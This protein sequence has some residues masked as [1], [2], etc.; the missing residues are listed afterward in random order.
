MKLPVIPAHI[1]KIAPLLL[2]SICASIAAV[3]YLQAL[4]YPF[5]IDDSL[6]ITENTRL[7]ELHLS[8]LWR[9]FVEPY[10]PTFEFLP[11]RDLSYWIDIAW[12]GQNPAAFRLHNLLLYLL[13]LPL[14]YATSA[15][16]WRTFRPADAASAPWAAA[17]VTAL[18]ALHPAL[19]ESV[20][21]ISG[22]KYIL[23]N[24]FALLAL[25]LAVNVKQDKTLSSRYA[26]AALLA[27]VAMMFSKSSYVAV[28]PVIALL[29]VIFWCDIPL[30][31]RR[32]SLLLWP[33]AILL[34][35]ALLLLLFIVKNKGFDT[36]PA[37]FGIEAISRSLAVLGGLV[38]IS[39]SPEA[40][41]FFHPVFENAG[42]AAMVALGGAAL[43]AAIW[44][45]AMLLR[46][47]SIIGLSLIAFVL[48]CLPYAQLLPAKPPSL[49]ADRYIAL[50]IWPLALLLVALAW[51]LKPLA[52]T[53]LL[54]L[55][56]LSWSFQTVQRPR[57]WRSSQTLVETDLRAYPG[58][59]L[60]ALFEIKVYQMP[61]GLL[62]EA[63][64]TAQSVTSP[65]AREVLNGLIQAYVATANS[66][67]TGWPQE[68]MARLWNLS[69]NLMQTPAPAKW[70]TPMLFFWDESRNM[71]A[72]LWEYLSKQFND[73]ALVHYN[74]GLY[75][76][77]THKPDFALPHLRTAAESQR[78]P[79][80]L[81]GTAYLNLGT[82]LN[83]V[84]RFT[85]AETAL[86]T[87]LAQSPPDTRAHCLLAEIYRNTGHIEQ[88]NK[89]EADCRKRVP[90]VQTAV[91]IFQ[92]GNYGAA[93]QEFQ[94]L[95]EHGNAIAQFFLGLMYYNGAGV[96]QDY[97]QAAAWYR[98]A[99]DLGNPDAQFNLGMM[100][101]NGQGVPQDWSQAQK[102][103]GLSALSGNVNAVNA[104]QEAE[105][106]MT[107]AQ[108]KDANAL[109]GKP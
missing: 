40:R 61:D 11:L 60:P 64:A 59:Y 12:F 26:L 1:R 83:K 55:I 58:Y 4:N 2:V 36:V 62:R 22:R 33:L 39:L 80:S 107:P 56:A 100:Y 68:A 87:A 82:A 9:L 35:G 96:V 25:W 69:L 16:L 75:L 42:F 53:A 41:H 74:A 90:D 98:K 71:L 52:R 78:L 86:N 108:L 79:E 20:V 81:R 48:L 24:F 30:P 49:V 23:A 76:L 101:R 54:V 88:T 109:I 95:A 105:T 8:E 73:D 34:A 32:R 7:A 28:A 31:Q 50:A 103:F 29:W 15:S 67:S 13:C 102:W 104:K 18:F 66:A 97:P 72:D 45:A 63:T 77:N 17:A 85:D 37:Y 84:G 47:R 89:A 3:A 94:P 38:R 91:N 27:L 21:W 93:L 19:V 14:V 57:D 51:R 10:N 6:Y 92:E 65:V 106:H 43:C 99:A 70:D 44:G 5:G 46:K